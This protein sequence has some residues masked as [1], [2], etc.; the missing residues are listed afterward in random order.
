[1]S[2]KYFKDKDG[3]TVDS[4]TAM[5]DCCKSIFG[6][7]TQTAAWGLAALQTM[8]FKDN[9]EKLS[10]KDQNTLR[11]L[12]SRVFY[13]VDTDEAI[14]LRLLG[15]PRNASQSLSKTMSSEIH[16]KSL[17][18]L[19]T[20]LVSRGSGLW[21]ESIGQNGEDYYKVWKILEGIV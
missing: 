9:F 14:S 5:G 21:T 3:K 17:N 15:V 19:R 11:N 18:E 20:E 7:L 4:T 8:T 2:D 6:K 13:G 1:M 12:P 16:D 10:E